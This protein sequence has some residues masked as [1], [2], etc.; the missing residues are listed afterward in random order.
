MAKSE[1]HIILFDDTCRLCNAGMKFVER[2]DK[3]DIY[4]FVPLKS[5]TG[6][7]FI[8]NIHLPE[9]TDSILV[10][11]AGGHYAE[12][13]AVLKI[14][15]NLHGMSKAAAIFNIIP[16]KLRDRIYRWVAANRYFLGKKR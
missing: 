9:N 7:K 6:G 14:L 5:E 8:S 12:S 13:E 11:Q 16:K 4:T 15:K 1:K 10:F 3:K 2:L